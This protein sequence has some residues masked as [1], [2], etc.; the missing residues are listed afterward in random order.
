M[1]TTK[2]VDVLQFYRPFLCFTFRGQCG[3]FMIIQKFYKTVKMILVEVLV[4][5]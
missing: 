3:L 2:N 5:K 4:A 1:V